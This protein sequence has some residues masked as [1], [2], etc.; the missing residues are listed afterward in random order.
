M[1]GRIIAVVFCL[2][3]VACGSE[4]TS[5]VRP[6]PVGAGASSSA[7]TT[8]TTTSEVTPLSGRLTFASDRDGAFYIYTATG[9]EVR[10]L[11]PGDRPKWSPNGAQIV[12]QA[13]APASGIYVMNADGSGQRY[14]T[15]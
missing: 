7:N 9:T 4:T 15:A 12:Y 6:S 11:A 13:A 5:P 2:G 10:R 1:K 8:P 3:A 14:L